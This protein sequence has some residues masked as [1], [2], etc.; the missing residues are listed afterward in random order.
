METPIP[1]Y[2]AAML[3]V[4]EWLDELEADDHHPRASI[5]AGNVLFWAV[6]LDDALSDRHPGYRDAA[7]ASAQGSVMLGLRFARNAVAHGFNLST[8]ARGLEWPMAWPIDWGPEVW[9]GADHFLSTW[10]PQGSKANVDE[11]I[12]VYRQRMEHRPV[13]EPLRD[14]LSWL[15]E[16]REPSGG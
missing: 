13:H 2:N 7:R 12:S 15:E 16:W 1:T 3:A 8:R 5:V 9:E 11:Q 10:S 6:S 4:H 14:A